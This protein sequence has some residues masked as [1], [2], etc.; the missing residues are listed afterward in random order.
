M[1]FKRISS[2]FKF[3]MERAMARDMHRG[4]PSGMATMRRTTA[5]TNI[6]ASSTTMVLRENGSPLKKGLIRVRNKS[7]VMIERPAANLANLLTW[8][9]AV[10]S[11]YS[12]NV[13]FSS[14]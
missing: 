14:Y 10:S 2:S 12:R 1:L 5:T 9:A 8:V 7:L 13:C 3:L 11:L 4:S 6:S